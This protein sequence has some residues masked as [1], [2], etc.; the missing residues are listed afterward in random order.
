M[1]PMILPFIA[2]VALQGDPRMGSAYREDKAGWVC[3]HL[4]GAPK[5]I[6]YQ[7]GVLLSDRID[8]AQQALHELLKRTTGKD[9]NFYRDTTRKLFW[10]HVPAEYQ[11]EIEGQA[12]GLQAKGLNY[13]QWDVLAFNGYIETSLYY[14]PWLQHQPA[15]NESCSAFIA[16]GSE[17]SD[18][19]IVMGQNMWWE[20]EMGER[21]NAILDIKPTNG[22]RILMDALCGFIHSGTDFAV[23]DAGMMVT[24]TT[25]PTIT[26]FDP[27]GTPEFVRMRQATQYSES[28]PQF[29]Q[30]MEAGNNGGYAN[31]WLVGDR[32]TN[33]I[34]RL[35]LGLKNV[36]W[37]TT[38]NGYF[39]GSNFPTNPKLV[40]EETSG[41]DVDPR[42]NGCE[43]RRQRWHQLLDKNKSLVDANLAKGFLADVVNP[44]TGAVGACDFTLCGRDPDFG[45]TNAKVMTSDLA[46]SMSFWGK[47]GAPDG[48]EFVPTSPSIYMRTLE[49]QAWTLLSIGK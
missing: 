16:T 12:E 17:T 26:D 24:E 21:F 46:G 43:A 37:E 38:K 30:I 40:Q 8:D 29:V 7:Y 2:A 35:E 44:I 27:N 15:K 31:T 25:L 48:A 20:L 18:G 4:A 39:V 49:P 5:D 34:G 33:E 19:K 13:D 32:R 1:I 45:A 10:D 3:A 6:G 11:Q 42:R 14:L 28:L 47:M 22:H 36:T 23:N 9:W 41:W